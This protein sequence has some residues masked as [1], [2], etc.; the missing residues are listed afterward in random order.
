MHSFRLALMVV[1]L[2]LAACA[3]GSSSKQTAPAAD[4]IVIGVAGPMSGDLAVFGEQLK[5]GAEQA[6]AD[7][8][9]EGGV[10]GKRLRLVV[11]DDQCDP[12]RAVRVANDLVA[13]GVV[14]VDGHFCSGSTIPASEVYGEIGSILQ[15]TPSSTNPKVTERGIAT[16]FRTTGRDDRQG[17][18]AGNWLAQTYSGKKIAV[19]DD[20]SS[21][22]ASL[23]REAEKALVANGQK[24]ALRDTYVQKE[25]DFSPLIAKLKQAD[26]A[27]V[28]VGGYHN[29][30][31]LLVRQAREQ[32]FTGDFASGDAL[33]TYEFWSI[34]GPAGDRVRYTD[35]S[36][37]VNLVSA[38]S[39]VEKLRADSYEPEGYTLGSYAA[40]QAWA[41]AAEIARTTEATKVADALHEGTL[42]TV[43]GVL[44]W[45]DKGDLVHPEYAWYVWDNGRAIEEP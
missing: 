8:N 34:A 13:Q 20:R 16:L 26:I 36:S 44:S 24:P 42:S 43:I 3:G 38:K 5:R 6:V 4:E 29:D 11:G 7:L 30:V 14:F 18:F 9:A 45:D 32:G 40:V 17:V 41:A 23:A 35:G 1:P 25:R 22:G 12:R 10:L 21:Y 27:A 37:P 2:L 19:L 39:V 28:Y 33:N 15:I 31:G